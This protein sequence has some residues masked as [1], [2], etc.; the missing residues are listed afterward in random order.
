MSFKQMAHQ[1][2][3]RYNKVSEFFDYED[4]ETYLG[5]GSSRVAFK[6]DDDY[7]IKISKNNIQ[8]FNNRPQNSRRRCNNGIQQSLKELEVWKNCPDH[9]KFLLNPIE[10]YGV[11]GGRVYLIQPLV[12]ICYDD[13]SSGDIYEVMDEMDCHD[14][15]F[16]NGV[17]E[18]C[19]HFELHSGDIYDNISNVGYSRD[20]GFV[21]TDYGYVG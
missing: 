9:L 12:E 14:E 5:E 4:F 1:A 19:H 20:Y 3:D 13:F 2:I 15:D 7:V 8:Q 18:L 11:Y 10:Y 16:L 6:L 17:G 21:I